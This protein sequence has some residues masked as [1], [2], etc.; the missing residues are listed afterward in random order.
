MGGT[1]AKVSGT[2]A[3]SGAVTI[4]V[5][6]AGASSAYIFTP[7]DIVMNTRTGERFLVATIAAATQITVAAAGRAF[8]TTAAAAGADGDGLFIIGNVNEENGIARNVNTTEAVRSDNYTQIQKDTIAIS[9]TAEATELYGGPDIK[10]QRAKVLIKHA[11]DIE[12]SALFGEKKDDA[13]GT[14]GKRRRATGGV[15]EHIETNSAYVQNQG[16]PLTIT[17]FNVFLREGFSYGSQTK[18]LMAGNLLLGAISEMARDHLRITSKETSFGLVIRSWDTQFGTVNVVHNPLMTYDFA[19]WGFLL[20][21][22]CYTYRFLAGNGV[23]RDTHIRQGVQ[24][25]DMDGKAD[26]VLTEWGLQREGA[27]RCALIK[28]ITG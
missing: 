2:Y 21:M 15:Q 11:R 26:E 9:G 1:Y 10:R 27:A 18:M 4:T 7:G 14:Q 23:N 6:G 24:V 22:D 16:G 12:K 5:S 13:N 28:G 19:G 17:D 3:A 8:G 25:P 20:D